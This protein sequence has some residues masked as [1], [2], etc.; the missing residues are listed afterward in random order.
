LLFPEGT[1]VDLAQKT[2][3]SLRQHGILS[4]LPV[5]FSPRRVKKEPARDEYPRDA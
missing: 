1:R 4:V 5:L 3:F 2:S